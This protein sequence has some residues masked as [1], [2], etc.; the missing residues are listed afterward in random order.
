MNDDPFD[1]PAFQDYFEAM[2]N[3]I[4]DF[5]ETASTLIIGGF[6]AILARGT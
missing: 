6:L 2:I 4:L 5:F 1:S 3:L